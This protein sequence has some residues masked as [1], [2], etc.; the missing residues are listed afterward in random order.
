M[1]NSE[2]LSCLFL[3]PRMWRRVNEISFQKKIQ[4][5]S[6]QILERKLRDIGAKRETKDKQESEMSELCR[7]P[8]KTEDKMEILIDISIRLQK[9]VFKRQSK[10]LLKDRMCYMWICLPFLQ[11]IL[12]YA[13]Y[14]CQLSIDAGEIIKNHLPSCSKEMWFPWNKKLT[15]FPSTPQYC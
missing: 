1:F 4:T 12:F 2:T 13:F 6:K 7:G 5:Q 3:T 11:I 9:Y 15:C 14:H 10:C 8:A